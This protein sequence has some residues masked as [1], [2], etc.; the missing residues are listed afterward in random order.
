LKKFYWF[1]LILFLLV[2][3][4]VFLFP[5]LLERQFNRVLLQN[6][7]EEYII[8]YDN[9]E[10][11]WWKRKVR[12]NDIQ[13]TRS[14]QETPLLTLKS[15]EIKD[16]SP[17]ALLFKRSINT[18]SLTIRSGELKLQE[19]LANTVN[20]SVN[21]NQV[22]NGLWNSLLSK[23]QIQ[24]LLLMDIN[25][26]LNNLDTTRL[27]FHLDSLQVEDIT[28]DTA[29]IHDPFPL[30]YRRIAFRFSDLFLQ[31]NPVYQC[32]IESLTGNQKGFI[33]LNGM[34]LY[35]ELSPEENYQRHD[36]TRKLLRIESNNLRLNNYTWRITPDYK[37][38]F[39]CASVNTDRVNVVVKD[40]HQFTIIPNRYRSLPSRFIRNL[41]MDLQIDTLRLKNCSV[42]YKMTEENNRTSSVRLDN[43]YSTAYNIH[44]DS[45][46]NQQT[47]FD[48][49]ADF[50]SNEKAK[51]RYVYQVNDPDDFFTFSGNL[52]NIRTDEINAI[53]YPIAQIKV[54]GQLKNL[55]FQLQGNENHLNGNVRFNYDNLKLN[56]LKNGGEDHALLKSALANIVL[57]TTNLP[58]QD[59]Y[60]TGTVDF[61]RNKRRSVMH[62]VWNGLR[63]G[64]LAILVPNDKIREKLLAKQ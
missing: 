45:T 38:Q 2:P 55:T 35:S 11:S 42:L 28:I 41:P 6:E 19:Q 12:V 57:N 17:L 40:D 59:K 64:I 7:D 49:I 1:L 36:F 21:P 20:T 15:F 60:K 25:V 48:I 31:L 26:Q 30:N 39:H 4:L 32:A 62:Y 37:L 54:L 8:Q 22:I 53:I 29:S 10:A 51:F 14:G 24:Q 3:L 13:I 52:N 5:F 56:V 46:S 50:L 23:I 47:V 9:L 18:N 63:G 58:E 43:I 33:N 16:V 44:N 61:P 34:Q 27:A